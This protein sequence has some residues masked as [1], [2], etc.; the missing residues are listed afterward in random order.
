MVIASNT[1]IIF[2]VKGNIDVRDEI[3]TSIDGIFITDGIFRSSDA[4]SCG[5]LT[6]DDPTLTINGAVYA[7]GEACF[8]RGL[9]DNST[10]PAEIINYEPTYLWLVQEIV[11][12]HTVMYREVAQ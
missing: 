2:V 4:A 11:G 6:D 7:F 5:N 10:E 3:V 9:S 12:D 1:G 8:T